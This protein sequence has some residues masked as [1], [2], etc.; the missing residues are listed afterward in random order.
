MPK[1]KLFFLFLLALISAQI[2]AKLPP[3]FNAN[4]INNKIQESYTF[5][6]AAGFFWKK[7]LREYTHSYGEQPSGLTVN[8]ERILKNAPIRDDE[9][10]FS[11]IVPRKALKQSAY[12]ILVS[13]TKEKSA[14]NEGDLWDS[15]K[16]SA[17]K[18]DNIYYKGTA[19]KP[20]I[21][22]FWKVRIWDNNNRTSDYSVTQSFKII[23]DKSVY[24]DPG[25]FQINGFKPIKFEKHNN[26]LFLDFSKDA[27]ATLTLSYKALKPETINITIGEQLNADGSINNKPAGSI[28]SH[29]VA[30]HVHPQ[31]SLYQISLKPDQR[32]T[33]LQAA[34]LPKSFPVL[35]PFRYVEISGNSQIIKREDVTQIRYHTYF[36]DLA[37]AFHSSNN[38]LN[39]VW[40]IC[41]YTIKA[42]SFTGLYMDGDRERIPYEGDAYL[43]QLSHYT[44]DRA[45]TIAK[46]SIEYFMQY[47]TWPTEWQLNV[48]LMMEQDYLYT[49]STKLIEKYYEQLKFKTLMGLAGE[50]GLI[51][52][53][54]PKLTKEF[55]K[56]LGFKDSNTR[57][58]DLV[59]WP[60]GE[61]DGFA[62]VPYNTVIN[63]LYVKNM[64]IMASFAKLLNKPKEEAVFNEKASIAKIA[65]NQKMLSKT[66]K[67]YTDGIGTEHASIHAN[68][69][70]LAFN[71]VPKE[72]IKPVIDFIKSRGMACSVYGAQYLME[73]LYNAN[74]A[75]YALSLM[76][77][78]SERSWYNMIRVGATMTMEAWDMKYK[79]NSD[80]N[81]P[82]GAA[83]AN[84]IPRLMW[85][86]Q[87]KTP[88]GSII[89]IK[90]QLS[91]L[92]Q[93]EI[94][95]PFLNGA[96]HA[97]Y[98]RS[99]KNKQVYSFDIPA[100]MLADVK[101][102][103]TPNQT[104]RINGKISKTNPDSIRL[105]PG[106]SLIELVNNNF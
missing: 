80:W 97:T 106:L 74:E 41:K 96:V 83:P 7:D 6:T 81:H 72:N 14:L 47:P 82:W 60:A 59:D 104:L 99:D 54:S 94:K 4:L 30:L 11:W 12:Q 48:A 56:N 36:D 69:F 10:V 63:V 13:S 57:L 42:T 91:N 40:D 93:T 70:A 90:P 2:F 92:T 100:N 58:V 73:A 65:I 76:T 79:P 35:T 37:S 49:G 39:Q 53:K 88:G 45:Y 9:P 1:P 20:V 67:V 78:T 34:Q 68:M 71:M 95:V 31:Q 51:S 19:L 17:N 28:R 101:L 38:I 98:K 46:N 15:K 55:M 44:T 62:F 8:F 52:T 61:R 85:G 50:D 103:N 26:K 5:L 32:N 29:D 84:V 25:I 105:K 27:F 87:P 18:S 33:K 16:V 89:A 102:T 86:I 66:T 21:S 3:A 22:Y 77:S 64:E 23:A 24:N 75:D 43:N